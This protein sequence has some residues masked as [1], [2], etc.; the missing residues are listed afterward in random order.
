MLY[1]NYPSLKKSGSKL[2]TTAYD[3]SFEISV[4]SVLFFPK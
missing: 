2:K 4:I 3:K 1:K